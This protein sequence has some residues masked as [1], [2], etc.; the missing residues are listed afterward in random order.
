MAET[1]A[2]SGEMERVAAQFEEVNDSLQ[3]TLTGLMTQLDGLHAGWRGLGATSFHDAKERWMDNQKV[4][5]TALA[6]TAAAI[7]TSGSSYGS[8]DAESASRVSRVSRTIDL[9]L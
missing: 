2:N 4:M 9:P 1:A 8:S 6:E 5:S 7:R 3:S